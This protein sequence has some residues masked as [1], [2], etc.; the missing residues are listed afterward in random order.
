[1]YYTY[2]AIRD[3]ARSTATR[4]AIGWNL[5]NDLYHLTS[6]QELWMQHTFRSL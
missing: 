4:S 5:T 6:Y 2:T 1:M 3:I